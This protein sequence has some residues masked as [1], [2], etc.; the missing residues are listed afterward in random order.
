MTQGDGGEWHGPAALNARHWADQ[1]GAGYRAKEGAVSTN[2]QEHADV[3]AI[4]IDTG[5]STFRLI[6]QDRRGKIVMRARAS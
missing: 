4:G 5:R 2:L 3:C 6:G 1:L